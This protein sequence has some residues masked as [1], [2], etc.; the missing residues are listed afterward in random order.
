[1]R[2]LLDENIPV[3]L[4]GYLRERGH[5]VVFV[6]EASPGIADAD[7]LAMA[8]AQ[9]RALLS[10]DRDHGD[11]IFAQGASAPR[12]VVYLRLMQPLPEHMHALAR[13]LAAMEPDAL[14]GYFTVISLGGM[15]QRSLPGNL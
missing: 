10:F 13:I 5:D 2:W 11:L 3:G 4:G 12:A 14:D 1:M 8:C 9:D 15:R 7:V 6:A